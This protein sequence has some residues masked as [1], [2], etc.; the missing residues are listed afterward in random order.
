MKDKIADRANI[1]IINWIPFLFM[2]RYGTDM[3]TLNTKY[4]TGDYDVRLT[5]YINYEKFKYLL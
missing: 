5:F 4:I 1:Y 2:I 3:D